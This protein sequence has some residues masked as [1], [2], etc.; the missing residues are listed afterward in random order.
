[1]TGPLPAN[2]ATDRSAEPGAASTTGASV[3]L[4]RYTSALR[5]IGW[6]IAAG[7]AR[8]AASVTALAR[9]R[10]TGRRDAGVLPLIMDELE[11]AHLVLTQFAHT[12]RLRMRDAAAQWGTVSPHPGAG[13]WH[14]HPCLNC[15]SART[16][17]EDCP[18][19]DTEAQLIGRVY[20]PRP[21]ERCSDVIDQPT[22]T[23][24]A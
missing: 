2:E 13:A 3:D 11:R 18:K 14:T 9:I 19:G 17:Y 21:C 8:R 10:A 12:A 16:C 4:G 24:A 7:G 15:G 22:E 1:M 5:A 23:K 6:G 20:E